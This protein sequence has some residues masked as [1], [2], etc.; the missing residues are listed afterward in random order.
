MERLDKNQ[1]KI[2]Q[3]M[4]QDSNKFVDLLHN[5]EWEEGLPA[6]IVQSN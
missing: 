3:N 4:M 5:I 2:Y 6:D 1:W